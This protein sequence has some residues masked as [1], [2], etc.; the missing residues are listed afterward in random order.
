DHGSVKIGKC[1]MLCNLLFNDK[2]HGLQPAGFSSTS[3]QEEECATV[4]SAWKYIDAVR[5][6]RRQSADVVRRCYANHLVAKRPGWD[7]VGELHLAGKDRV[8]AAIHDH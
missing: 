7:R 8:T 1:T 5:L 6:T 3:R 2:A 4:C